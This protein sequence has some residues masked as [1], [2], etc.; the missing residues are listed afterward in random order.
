VILLRVVSFIEDQNID[1]AHLNEAIEQALIE[2]L[3]CADDYHVFGKVIVP[4]LLVPEVWSHR[5]ENVCHIL[6]EII[7]QHRRLLKYKSYAV[8]LVLV[9]IGPFRGSQSTYQEKG[10]PRSLAICT[11]Y[12]LLLQDVLE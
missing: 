7:L 1:L 4:D 11:V 3:S 5:T 2:D 6:V 9:S 12:Q 8:S 10:N